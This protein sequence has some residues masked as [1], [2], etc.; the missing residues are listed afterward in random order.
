MW[1]G[2]RSAAEALLSN[3]LAL[4]RAIIDVGIHIISIFH[5]FSVINL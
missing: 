5:Y 3:D 4:A 2:I 1:Q